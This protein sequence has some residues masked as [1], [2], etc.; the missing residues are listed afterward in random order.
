MR[1]KISHFEQ[2]YGVK[3]LAELVCGL[4]L[5]G[6]TSSKSYMGIDLAA[7]PVSAPQLSI[8]TLAIL[9]RAGDK[10]AQLELGIRFEA[11][12]ARSPSAIEEL[13]Q[14]NLPCDL[15]RAEKLYRQATTNSGGTI[16]V[17]S[18]PPWARAVRVGPSRLMAGQCEWGWLKPG[19]V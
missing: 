11:A 2:I 8:Q 6:C 7:K 9:S 1:R 16:W 10:Q 5:A 18:P 17:Y 13:L 15:K 19:V 3:Q 12:C 4:L 14:T